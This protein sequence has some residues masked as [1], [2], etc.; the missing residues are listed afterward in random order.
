MGLFP[1]PVSHL[2]I[3]P[4]S[5]SMQSYKDECCCNACD[6]CQCT[7]C[8]AG[9]SGWEAII[10]MMPF[11]LGEPPLPNL[12]CRAREHCCCASSLFCKLGIIKCTSIIIL[13]SEFCLSCSAG[14]AGALPTADQLHE[15]AGFDVCALC[16]GGAGHHGRSK[17]DACNKVFELIP[18]LTTICL[19]FQPHAA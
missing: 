1:G 2:V 11:G 9:V 5:L 3:I 6:P 17:A 12:P 15:A 7:A 19:V 16:W 13:G 18:F 4:D 10:T 8:H 14:A